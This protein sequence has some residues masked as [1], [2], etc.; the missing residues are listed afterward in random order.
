MNGGGIWEH[1]PSRQDIRNGFCGCLRDLRIPSITT[2]DY[3]SFVEGTPV[4][5]SHVDVEYVM[6]Y[7]PLESVT[8]PLDIEVCQV[9]TLP[10]ELHH[11]SAKAVEGRVDIEWVT[12]SEWNNDFFTIERSKTLIFE[13]VARVDGA[14]NS[15]STSTISL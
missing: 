5:V 10:I 3:P 15:T 12:A 1:L 6:T 11:F 2:N 8:V 7:R 14:G 13:E 4:S 9:T